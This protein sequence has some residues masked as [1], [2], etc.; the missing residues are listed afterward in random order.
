M[1]SE[2]PGGTLL[3]LEPKSLRSFTTNDE[4]LYAMKE[5]LADWFACLYK[6]Q[7]DADTFLA[8]LETG[9]VLCRHANEVQTFFKDRR[10]QGAALAMRSY[11]I[12]SVPEG[13][14]TC[15]QD[16]KPGTFQARDNVSNFIT[17]CRRLGIPDVLR[18]ETDDLVLRKNEKSVILCLLELARVGAKLGMLAPT[19]VQMEQE[20]DEEIE[21]GEPPP[22]IKTCDMKTLE[23]LVRELV[24]QCTCP[25][26]FP[27]NKVGEGKYQIGDS[28]TLIFVRV[29]R[30][31]VMVRVG[32]GW[33]TLENY[34]DKHDPCRCQYKGHRSGGPRHQIIRRA[35]TSNLVATRGAPTPNANA[36][37]TNN[38]NQQQ[39]PL[40]ETEIKP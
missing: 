8:I 19:L 38:N 4:Y 29:L 28:R 11:F 14:V 35:S 31:H 6:L 34:L 36:N 33:D 24:G 25:V 16:V 1:E 18:F 21:S 40:T 22:Q 3:V 39:Q 27:M 32:G 9:V 30:N 5:D 10:Q 20:I 13:T 37:N 23:E 7:M 17:W 26:Q 2:S 15:R 12:Q